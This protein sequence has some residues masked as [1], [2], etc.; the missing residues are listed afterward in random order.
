MDSPAPERGGGEPIPKAS[1]RWPTA[2]SPFF[3][4][5]AH[6]VFKIL[7]RTNGEES[8]NTEGGGQ[9]AYYFN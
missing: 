7:N 2:L 6:I 1:E 5:R 9:Y 3:N 4:N 8:P